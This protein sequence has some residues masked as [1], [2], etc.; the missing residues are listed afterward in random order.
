MRIAVIDSSCLINLTHLGLAVAVSQFFHL[1]YVPRSV[2]QEVNRKSR[3]RYK[4]KKLYRTRV[5][6]RCQVADEVRV[7]WLADQLD[8]GEA[9][10]LIQ[11]KERKAAY[12]LG[13]ERRAREVGEL[14]GI[15]PVGTARLLARLHLDGLAGEP[16]LLVNKLRKDLGC[17]IAEEVIDEAITRSRETI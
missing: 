12:F 7:K 6:K 11:A 8:P 16:R 17:R 3:F 14:M 9:E 15:Q 10:A 2:H 13:D 5:Y 1:I 4:L